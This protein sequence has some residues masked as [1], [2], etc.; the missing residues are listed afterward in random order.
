MHYKNGREAKA[1]DAI[2]SL[3]SGQTGI[4]YDQVAGIKQ[5]S[6]RLAKTTL[7]DEYVT[8]EQ[9]LHLDDVA[10]ATVPNTTA[11]ASTPPIDLAAAGLPTETEPPKL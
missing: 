5:C 11:P 7:N 8:L 10:A 6:A 4:L 3:Q 9:C 2:L 1:G